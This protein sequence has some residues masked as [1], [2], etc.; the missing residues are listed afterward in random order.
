MV[1]R[2]AQRVEGMSEAEVTAGISQRLCAT[3]EDRK[4]Q[5]QW[6]NLIVAILRGAMGTAGEM[7]LLQRVG[8]DGEEGEWDDYGRWLGLRHARRIWGEVMSNAMAILVEVVRCKERTSSLPSHIVFTSP[9]FLV[10]ARQVRLS[11]TFHKTASHAGELEKLKVSVAEL[12]IDL[13]AL[14]DEKKDSKCVR[15]RYVG[16][17]WLTT[18]LV[19]LSTYQDGGEAAAAA[20]RAQIKR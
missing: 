5:C 18:L 14:P 8:F 16:E 20:A 6:P 10:L 1:G 3:G 4:A 11:L 17:I 7:E 15:R 12:V 2:G 9:G 19:I 13:M